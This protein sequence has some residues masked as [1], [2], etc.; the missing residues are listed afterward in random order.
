MNFYKKTY[1]LLRLSSTLLHSAQMVRV[2]VR[3]VHQRGY[4]EY[5][6]TWT[7]KFH[8]ANLALMNCK[9]TDQFGYIFKRYGSHLTDV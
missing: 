5:Y 4:N 9:T 8:E 7:F 2:P 3:M 1:H 6:D